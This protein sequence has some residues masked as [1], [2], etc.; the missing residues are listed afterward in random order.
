M[1]IYRLKLTIVLDLKFNEGQILIFLDKLKY[2]PKQDEELNAFQYTF[3]VFF[4]NNIS[5]N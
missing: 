4:L 3:I 2:T 5:I 1:L